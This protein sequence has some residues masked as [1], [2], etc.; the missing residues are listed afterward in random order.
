LFENGF[1]YQTILSQIQEVNEFAELR[2]FFM[3]LAEGYRFAESVAANSVFGFDH[4]GWNNYITDL[5]VS[6]VLGRLIDNINADTIYHRDNDFYYFS[7]LEY[8]DDMAIS[9]VL[10]KYYE[11]D[12]L[13]LNDLIIN[14]L[15]LDSEDIFDSVDYGIFRDV[16]SKLLGYSEP[17]ITAYVDHLNRQNLINQNLFYQY[18]MT[19]PLTGWNLN[20]ANDLRAFISMLSRD[21]LDVFVTIIYDPQGLGIQLLNSTNNPVNS[22]TSARFNAGDWK[23]GGQFGFGNFGFDSSNSHLD[24]DWDNFNNYNYYFG[25]TNIN[26]GTYPTADVVSGFGFTVNYGQVFP[27]PTEVHFRGFVLGA[28]IVTPHAISPAGQI[29]ATTVTDQGIHNLDYI[30]F[31]TGNKTFRLNTYYVGAASTPTC[32]VSSGVV[33]RDITIGTAHGNQNYF[34]HNCVDNKTS[35]MPATVVTQG[36]INLSDNNNMISYVGEDRLNSATPKVFQYHGYD[37]PV[38]RQYITYDRLYSGLYGAGGST[39]ITVK[40]HWVE[41]FEVQFYVGEELIWTE[42]V[43]ESGKA[44]YPNAVTDP[45]IKAILIS[46]GLEFVDEDSAEWRFSGTTNQ[47]TPGSIITDNVSIVAFEVREIVYDIHY[48]LSLNQLEATYSETDIEYVT[49][50]AM[51][52]TYGAV[53]IPLTLPTPSAVTGY[54]F[55]GWEVTG[56]DGSGIALSTIITDN[57]F[58]PSTAGNVTLTAVWEIESFEIQSAGS[59]FLQN[60]FNSAQ[61]VVIENESITFAALTAITINNLTSGDT[62]TITISGISTSAVLTLTGSGV[63]ENNGT[64]TVEES[65][66]TATFEFNM[67]AENVKYEIV[68]TRPT[69]PQ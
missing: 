51:L 62:I 24:V 38:P 29:F 47:W 11:E 14:L 59:T 53:D 67:P 57:A 64:Y 43:D 16:L 31:G 68:V 61:L 21:L 19:N 15:D 32:S 5:E 44:I 13:D 41:V 66:T 40:A 12:A 9:Y 25:T 1:T 42:Y 63:T 7:R 52:I 49:L 65:A 2:D 22:G 34:S 26:P 45:S 20:S 35:S 28:N 10:A 27:I 56:F 17:N 30:V 69:D 55:I 23:E 18:L 6:L 33:T 50:S 4:I 58:D 48:E 54:A 36:F 37:W 8:F 60:N 39:P 3:I 46:E